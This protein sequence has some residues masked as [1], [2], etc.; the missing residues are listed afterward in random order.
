MN[1]NAF[2]RESPMFYGRYQVV[3]P[4]GQTENCHN[5]STAR[6]LRDRVN[7]RAGKKKEYIKEHQMDK[8]ITDIQGVID[9]LE[10]IL[11]PI[12]DIHERRPIIQI[13]QFCQRQQDLGRGLTDI[14]YWLQRELPKGLDKALGLD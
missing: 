14:I 3:Y 7:S 2:V 9:V 11:E 1:E 4:N 13:I 12:T 8:T 10:D 6:A 5:L